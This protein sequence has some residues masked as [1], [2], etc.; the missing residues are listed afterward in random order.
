MAMIEAKA[1]PLTK[2]DQIDLLVEALG[3][4]AIAASVAYGSETAWR[5]ARGVQ[6][7]ETAARAIDRAGQ[8]SAG[9]Y[10]C[11]ADET[12]ASELKHGAEFWQERIT[13]ARYEMD[14]DL[15]KRCGANATQR[16]A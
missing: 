14:A 4:A 9:L 7:L 16:A 3:D 1:A 5:A 2:A 11:A 6:V 8:S 13:R 10:W 15:D 12:M